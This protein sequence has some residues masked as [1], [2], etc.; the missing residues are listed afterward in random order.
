MDKSEVTTFLG[1]LGRIATA[2]EAQ[3][4]PSEPETPAE[5]TETQNS[6]RSAKKTEGG[7]K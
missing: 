1:Y 2:L 7:T 6:T 5:T 4:T 3:V